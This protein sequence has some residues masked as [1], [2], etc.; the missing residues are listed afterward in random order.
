M[1]RDIGMMLLI[2]DTGMIVILIGQ[3]IVIVIN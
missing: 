3:T 1:E 2:E